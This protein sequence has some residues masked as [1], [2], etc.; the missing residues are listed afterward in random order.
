MEAFLASP[1]AIE[2]FIALLFSVVIYIIAKKWSEHTITSLSGHLTALTEEVKKANET[3]DK[4]LQ[5]LVNSDKVIDETIKV[6]R[7]LQLT[8]TEARRDHQEILKEIMRGN[9]ER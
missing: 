4:M 9:N 6:L 5:V 1:L 2:V 3:N 8:S 7:E